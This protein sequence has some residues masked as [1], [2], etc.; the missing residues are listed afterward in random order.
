MLEFLM[1]QVSDDAASEPNALLLIAQVVTAFLS[2]PLVVTVLTAVGRVLLPSSR[3]RNRIT[4]DLAIYEKLPESA[5]KKALGQQI[6]GLVDALIARTAP[7]TQAANRAKAKRIALVVV[8]IAIVVAGV[9]LL[10]LGFKFDLANSIVSTVVSALL[11]AL[12]LV[13]GA[14]ASRAQ[15]SSE[16]SFTSI[17]STLSEARQAERDAMERERERADRN[18]QRLERAEALL[19]EHGIALPKD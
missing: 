4:R 2:I 3:L 8:G 7:S 1:H 13:V 18:E 17:V 10:Y 12:T 5:T 16:E 6:E 15:K 14:F 11:G 19:R 9:V